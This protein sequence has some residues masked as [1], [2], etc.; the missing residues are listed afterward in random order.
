MKVVSRLPAAESGAYRMGY[1]VIAGAMA[2]ILAVTIPL[3]AGSLPR[4]LHLIA[5]A[6]G[7]G[8]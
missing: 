7:A 3:V 2:L 6:F 1:A 8:Y 4:T 5:N